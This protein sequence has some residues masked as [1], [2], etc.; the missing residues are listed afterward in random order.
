MPSEVSIPF[1]AAGVKEPDLRSGAWIDPTQVWTFVM[2]ASKASEGE[3]APDRLS[4][5][6]SGDNVIDLKRRRG[7]CGWKMTI[8]APVPS[9]SPD[10]L[11]Q[12][13]KVVAHEAALRRLIARLACE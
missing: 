6:L 4:R 9:S 1:V 3:I 11:L 7:S 5:V 12:C 8:L 2:I 10:E 13:G